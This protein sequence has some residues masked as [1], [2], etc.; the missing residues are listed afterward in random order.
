[1][2]EPNPWDAQGAYHPVPGGQQ[3]FIADHLLK[4]LEVECC[5]ARGFRVGSDNPR[6]MVLLTIKGDDAS[7]KEAITV[8][9]VPEMAMEVIRSIRHAVQGIPMEDR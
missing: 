8:G 6:G 2:S 7:G 5:A 4:A 1:M 9:L 3:F